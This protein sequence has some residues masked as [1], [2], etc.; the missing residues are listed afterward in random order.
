MS[1]WLMELVLKTS[2]SARGRGF[3]S[4]SLRQNLIVFLLFGTGEIPKFGRRGAPAKGV[5]RVTG[6]RVQ[7]PLSPPSKNR[8]Q[9]HPVFYFLG[10]DLNPLGNKMGA[11]PDVMK[12]IK[13]SL[14]V[15]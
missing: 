2:D 11:N 13:F 1:E 12:Q 10:I 14:S 4:L 6:A 3:K 7:I 8:M 5:G 9:T 15:S